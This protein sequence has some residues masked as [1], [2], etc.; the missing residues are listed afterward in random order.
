METV[1]LR[2]R[3]GWKQWFEAEAWWKQWKQ[4]KH[5]PNKDFL[6]AH[7]LGVPGCGGTAALACARGGTGE[8]F[9]GGTGGEERRLCGSHRSGKGTE[10]VTHSLRLRVSLGGRARNGTPSLSPPSRARVKSAPVESG[11]THTAPRAARRGPTKVHDQNGEAIGGARARLR[12]CPRTWAPPTRPTS[13]PPRDEVGVSH[14]GDRSRAAG[15]KRE[16]AAGREACAGAEARLS[17]SLHLVWPSPLPSPQFPPPHRLT[18]AWA[19]SPSEYE[20]GGGWRGAPTA[21]CGRRDAWSK[22]LTSA[23]A[24]AQRAPPLRHGRAWGPF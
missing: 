15:V 17:P 24:H 9:R 8:A 1:V 11:P 18:T 14:R 5:A 10:S 3:R 23:A 21:E 16:G 4:W 7:T 19:R 6:G 22:K 20:G 13:P 2:G 12:R